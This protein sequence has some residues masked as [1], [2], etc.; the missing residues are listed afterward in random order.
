[1]GSQTGRV[2]PRQGAYGTRIEEASALSARDRRELAELY[3]K[4]YTATDEERFLADLDEKDEVLIID[5]D[6][7]PV[8]FTTLRIYTHSWRG[9]PIRVVFSGDTVVEQAHWGQQAL[10]H[11]W[12][13]RM[14]RLK[15]RDGQPLFWFLIVKGHRTYRYL[16]A[17]FK[18]Y[19]PHHGAQPDE[20]K[21]LADALARERFGESYNPLSGVV[22]FD[23]PHGH[24]AA[25]YTEPTEQ[26]RA[27]PEVRYFLQRNPGYRRGD[28]LVCLAE[29]SETNLRPYTLRAF[30]RAMP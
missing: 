3:L 16:P 1:M 25:E 21:P 12:I 27:R 29:I 24:L 2:H 4:Y 13:G 19:H 6:G 9:A 18:R 28:E 11:G 5:F 14:A 20:L 15:A 17:F 26:E 8:G 23:R 30:T 10:A 22:S 7:R